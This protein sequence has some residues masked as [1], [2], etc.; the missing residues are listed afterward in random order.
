MA[1]LPDL[2][3]GMLPQVS[4]AIA[5]ALA[6]L[7]RT[8]SAEGAWTPL[9]FGNQFALHEENTTYGTAR[10]VSALVP[11]AA[12]GDAAAAR[13]VARGT[14]WLLAAQNWGGAWGGAPA[15]RPSIEE[16]ALAVDALAQVLRSPPT[17]GAAGRETRCAHYGDGAPPSPASVRLAVERGTEWLIRHTDGGTR[18]DPAPIGFYFAALWYYERLYPVIFTLSALE[19]VR[20]HFVAKGNGE[21]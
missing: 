21:G 12:R 2:P 17:A 9:W 15:A 13:M 4:A 1:W 7:E 5:R 20:A 11:A 10:V 18:F 3:A 19:R 8:Q 6:Y 14:Q 16:T